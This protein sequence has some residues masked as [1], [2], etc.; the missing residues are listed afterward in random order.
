MIKS[1]CKIKITCESHTVV[2]NS[3]RPH[4][5]YSPWNSLCQNTGVGSLSLL[6]GIFLAQESNHALLHCRWILYQRREEVSSVAQSCLTLCDPMN[7]STPRL[8]ITNFRSLLKLLSIESVMP[9][10]HILCHS[11]LLLPPI[12]PSI[13]VFFNT[14][15]QLHQKNS[16][17]KSHTANA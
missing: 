10:S 16:L 11:L 2:S 6:Q 8:S 12:P 1:S 14:C 5:L 3:L 15:S 4:G 17:G 9:S 13:R 7:H